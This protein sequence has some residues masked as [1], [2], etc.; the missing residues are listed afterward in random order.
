MDVTLFVD[1]NTEFRYRRV[2]SAPAEY[3]TVLTIQDSNGSKI[4]LFVSR[5]MVGH[6][7][8]ESLYRMRDTIDEA[9]AMVKGDD[10]ED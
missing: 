8:L 5:T 1:Q 7:P 3:G 10:D 2:G 9:I 6:V 4:D